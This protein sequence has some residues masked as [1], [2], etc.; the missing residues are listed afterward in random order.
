MADVV[1]DT[2]DTYITV[3]NQGTDSVTLKVDTSGQLPLY[4]TLTDADILQLMAGL[5]ALL[6]SRK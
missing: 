5:T 4:I 1:L 6:D 2:P 3:R